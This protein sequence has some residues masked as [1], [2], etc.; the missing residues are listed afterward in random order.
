M[1]YDVK[2]DFHEAC[3]C[4]IICSCWAGFDP[5]MGSCSGLFAW[6]IKSGSIDGADVAGAQ[7][8]ILSQGKSCDKS[9]NMLVLID[10]PAAQFPAIKTAVR[11][12]PWGAVFSAVNGLPEFVE[13][14]ITIGPK[15]L[16]ARLKVP[17]PKR[18]VEV[19]ANYAFTAVE[20]TD[21]ASTR[22]IE[23]VT[24]T[25]LS[26]VDVGAIE[27]NAAG[28]GLNM[29]AEVQAP[30]SPSYIFDLDVTRV[31]AMRGKFHYRLP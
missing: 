14:H 5:D 18:S 4:E 25:S 10:A 24:G 29:L 30:G 7:V 21:T 20:L 2:G 12:G 17:D 13:A 11:S 1:T 3:D 26:R 27:T 22:L 31:T 8:I 28:I 15:K 16:K 9:D 23:R 6:D 19:D